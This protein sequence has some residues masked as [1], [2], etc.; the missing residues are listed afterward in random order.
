MNTRRIKFI[1]IFK[2]LKTV[3]THKLYVGYYCFKFG[4]PLQGIIH[5]FSKFSPVEFWESVRYYTGVRSPI[6]TCKEEKGYSLAWQ[7]HKG[8]N[9]HHY[10]Y[11]VDEMDAGGK[12]LIMPYRYALEML[13]DYLGAGKAY[14]G[15]GFTFAK[16]YEWWLEK[17][18]GSLVMHPVTRKFISLSLFKLCELEKENP[19]LPQNRI[20]YKLK[21]LHKSKNWLKIMYARLIKQYAGMYRH[22]PWMQE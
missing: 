15:R 10:H 16:E 7:H 3:C 9:K 18:K 17:E 2:H 20:L 5:D 21:H 11:W 13:C 4:I 19:D 1:N 8:K 14:N 22:Y 12:A 6:D